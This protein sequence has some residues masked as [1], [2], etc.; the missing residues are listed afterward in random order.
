MKKLLLIGAGH[1]HVEVLRQFSLHPA[2]NAAITMVSPQRQMTYAGMLPGLV[3]GHYTAGQCQ[4]DLGPLAQKAGIELLADRVV[5]LDAEGQ[6][7]M[8]ASGRPLEFDFASIDIG[9]TPFAPEVPGLRRFALLA[10]PVEVFLEG[11]NRV[12]ELARE[13]GLSRLTV[14]GGGAAAVEL[15]LAM[16]HRLRR[17]LPQSAFGDFGFSI[18]T[19]GPRLL[20]ELPEQL[21][22]AVE[23]LCVARGISLLRGATVKLVE[24]DGLLLSNGAQLASDITVWASGAYAARWLAAAGLACDMGGIMQT[25][26]SLRSLSHQRIYGAGD[27]SMPEQRPRPFMGICGLPQGPALAANLRHALASQPSLR[28]A[29]PP[30]ERAMLSLGAR[31]AFGMRGAAML[32]TPHWFNWRWKDWV[33]RRWVR[34]FR[35][36]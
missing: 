7:A 29:P 31:L 35:V 2:A 14:V 8:T 22:L 3:A 1:A 32:N 21:G 25:D 15:M 24:R 11:W 27:C 13:G 33:D 23:A 10:K 36:G 20:D 12:R 17:E 18:V 19:E 16:Q 30:D 26:A 28:W 34:R 6:V 9:V 5:G 4:V